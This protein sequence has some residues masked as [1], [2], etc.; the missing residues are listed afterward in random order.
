MISLSENNSSKLFVVDLTLHVKG[1]NNVME[2][3]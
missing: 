3:K 2:N 1:K